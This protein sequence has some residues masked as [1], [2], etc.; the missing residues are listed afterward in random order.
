LG[1]RKPSLIQT[2]ISPQ[3]NPNG[4]LEA[5][6]AKALKAQVAEVTEILADNIEA[7]KRQGENFQ[8]MQAKSRNTK[9]E[10]H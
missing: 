1:R 2:P 3:P 10:Q 7:F 6:K 5:D 8:S 4:S 9:R